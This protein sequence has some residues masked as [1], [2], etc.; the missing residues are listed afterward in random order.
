[1]AKAIGPTFGGELILAGLGGLD[2]TWGSD[3]S[4]FWGPSITQT[5]KNQVLA[6][7]N[8]HDPVK[9]NLL[10]YSENARYLVETA[11]ITIDGTAIQTDLQSQQLLHATYSYC[12]VYTAVTILWKRP[13]YS[14][15]P[16]TAAQ[17]N[18]LFLTVQGFVE[19]CFNMEAQINSSITAGTIT[20]TAQI[21]A[22]YATIITV[23]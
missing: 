14:F 4:F 19:S 11:Y 9:S 12:Q 18:H 15:V 16:Y 6:V 10:D 1:M 17:I 2:F 21:D 22:L 5:Q 13:D 3:G 23:F 8:A 20:T 7:Y